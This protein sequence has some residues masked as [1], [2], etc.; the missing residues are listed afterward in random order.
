MSPSRSRI[1]LSSVKNDE[2]KRV[3][4]QIT[5]S[6]FNLLAEACQITGHKP[7]E[8]LAVLFRMEL[9]PRLNRTLSDLRKET[10]QKTADDVLIEKLTAPT[11][12]SLRSAPL[13]PAAALNAPT[14]LGNRAPAPSTLP[15]TS[16]PVPPAPTAPPGMARTSTLPNHPTQMQPTPLNAAPTLSPA[17]PP[18]AARSTPESSQ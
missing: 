4:I 17:Q 10:E 18:S 12:E 8:L 9:K 2:M 16:S 14:P 15:N 11:H 5:Q 3:T 13:A 7:T 6:E 1:D